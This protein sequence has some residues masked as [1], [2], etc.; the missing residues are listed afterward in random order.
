M[1]HHVASL[2]RILPEPSL[3]WEEPLGRMEQQL[4]PIIRQAVNGEVSP[5]RLSLNNDAI[6]VHSPSCDDEVVH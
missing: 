6:N 2:V 3:V 5:E 1:K 4:N